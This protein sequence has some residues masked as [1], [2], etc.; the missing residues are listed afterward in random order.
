[1]RALWLTS[2]SVA[3]SARAPATASPS[4]SRTFIVT[5]PAR[6]GR[7]RCRAGSS[8]PA[9]DLAP[10]RPSL[11]GPIGRPDL[12]RAEAR[13][14]RAVPDGH[15]LERVA[16]AAGQEPPHAERVGPAD[17]VAAGP[18]ARRD[19]R[20]HRPLHEPHALAALDLPARLAGELKVQ[21]EIV[22]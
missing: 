4:R 17:R 11:A 21:T 7:A 3:P 19:P 8:E 1:V 6:C 16:L 9:R 12:D 22:D 2:T 18:E 10:W 14:R 15:E 13:R 20:V 5:P